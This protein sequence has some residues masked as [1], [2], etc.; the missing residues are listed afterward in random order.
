MNARRGVMR[1][2]ILENICGSLFIPDRLH[3]IIGA[4][5]LGQ[6]C[7]CLYADERLLITNTLY[8]CGPKGIEHVLTEYGH[9][10]AI[11][12][13]REAYSSSPSC[14]MTSAMKYT[15]RY[16]TFLSLAWKPLRKCLSRRWVKR[17]SVV[18]SSS[19][20]PS[21]C[22]SAAEK[23]M[24]WERREISDQHAPFALRNLM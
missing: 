16:R 1:E 6:G 18:S 19:S 22:F 2:K 23:D 10:E 12:R 14:E 9:N 13:E 21:S 5:D 15:T 17:V 24:R 3:G 11:E 8:E 20:M 7:D 4:T